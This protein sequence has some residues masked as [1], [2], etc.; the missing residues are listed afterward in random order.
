MF[1][2]Q[3]SKTIAKSHSNFLNKHAQELMLP[4]AQGQGQT[5]SSIT[6]TLQ[7]HVKTLIKMHLFI[8]QRDMNELIL[9]TETTTILLEFIQPARI[10][11]NLKSCPFPSFLPTCINGLLCFG[12]QIFKVVCQALLQKPDGHAMLWITDWKEGK[13]FLNQIT[14]LG[15][16]HIS[17]WCNYNNM[18]HTA[19]DL[20]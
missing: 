3:A 13:Q 6:S 5:Y 12:L 18:S 7:K 16:K 17:K 8:W 19:E 20:I 11:S 1:F 9:Y 15:N 14:A 4:N 10:L 2:L